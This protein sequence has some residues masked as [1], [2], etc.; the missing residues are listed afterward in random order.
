M[1]SEA[2]RQTYGERTNPS[3]KAYEATSHKVW[4]LKEVKVI[5]FSP[6]DQQ[7]RFIRAVMERAS[8]LQTSVLK[9]YVPC[10][11]CE[12]IG[13]LPRSE[14]LPAERTF[15]KCKDEQN[16]IVNQLMRDKAYPHVQIIFGN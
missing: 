9:D 16:R 14:R 7:M 8:N 10:E 3:W 12:K 13:V 5:G 2:R 1:D 11:D 6:M 15:P 4:L